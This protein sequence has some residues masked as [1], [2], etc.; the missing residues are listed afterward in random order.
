MNGLEQ[1]DL[2]SL[3][4]S[5]LLHELSESI[6]IFKDKKN[7][8]VDCTLGMGGHA[9]EIIKRLNKGDIFIG[10]DADKRNLDIA[11]PYLL[12]EF[13]GKG[14]EFFFVNDNFENLKL[15]L[16]KIGIEYITGIYYD[17]GISSLH[18][19]EAER[20]FSFKLNGPLDMRYNVN[21]GI[22]ASQILNSYKEDELVK[23]FFEY[24]EES[25]AKKIAKE[26]LVKRKSG[27][28]FKDTKDLTSLIES[29]TS[30]PKTK[31]KIFQALRIEVNK[32][33]ETIEKSIKDAI[34]LLLEGGS[35][36]VISFHSLEDRI[37]KNIFRDETRDCN[38]RELIC[39]CRHKKRLKNIFKKPLLPSQTEIKANPRSR[40]A[41]ARF[42]I[43]LANKN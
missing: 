1:K 42:A 33:L 21:S 43:K 11:K 39:V 29:I 26:I 32:E 24:G 10:F 25:Q 15:N 30:Y 35:I 7:I 27:F 28:R 36:F 18:V 22:T 2:S 5:V 16:S 31:N 17:L 12:K 3:H 8:I 34:E 23:I 13:D 4:K 20:G 37:I 41:K 38:C 19:D 40:S 6:I 9:K 14:I